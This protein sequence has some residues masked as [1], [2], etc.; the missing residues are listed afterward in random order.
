MNKSRLPDPI[1]DVAQSVV[2][3]VSAVDV[4]DLSDDCF[5]A[6]IANTH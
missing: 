3:S 6:T 1:S 5:G 4:V 2:V